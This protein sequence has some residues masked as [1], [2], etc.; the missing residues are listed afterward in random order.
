MK[1]KLCQHEWVEFKQ[2]RNRIMHCR[3]CFISKQAIDNTEKMKGGH[4]GN[5]TSS[6]KY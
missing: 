4:N 3:K 2:G 6:R 5:H 1:T